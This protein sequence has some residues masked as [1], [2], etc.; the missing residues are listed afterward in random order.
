MYSYLIYVER[1]NV[2]SQSIIHEVNGKNNKMNKMENE[3]LHS[4]LQ[5]TS[6]KRNHC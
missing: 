6:H 2:T 4:L 1:K 5:Q 3:L